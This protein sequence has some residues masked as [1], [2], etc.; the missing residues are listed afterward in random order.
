VYKHLGI[1]SNM[2]LDLKNYK[3]LLF[4]TTGISNNIDFNNCI[5]Q[6]I[7]GIGTQA[8]IYS[9]HSSIK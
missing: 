7:T 3:A 2:N 9:D 6:N 1:F 4:S 5:F 8:L